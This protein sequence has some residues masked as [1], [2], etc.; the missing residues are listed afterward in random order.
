MENEKKSI[1]LIA[2]EEEENAAFDKYFELKL[3]KI[4][5]NDHGSL[6]VIISDI[7]NAKKLIELQ[8][9][10]HYKDRLLASISHDLR[11]PLNGVIGM[12]N[13]T[14]TQISD[15]RSKELLNI[16]LKSAHLLEFLIKDILDF[17]QFSYKKLRLNVDF[18]SLDELLKEVMSLMKF[19]AQNREI[20]LQCCN[21]IKK[22]LVG[23]SDPNRIKQILINLLGNAIKFT[24][25][26]FVK[27]S[28]D[29]A[30]EQDEIAINDEKN[31][32]LKFTVEDSGIGIK[33]EDQCH[34]FKL[35]GKLE[36]EDPE[37]NKNGIGL[38]LAI[39]NTLA[40]LL[41]EDERKNGIHLD[42]V[43]GKGSV[44]SFC[45]MIGLDNAV[46]KHCT[47]NALP[48]STNLNTVT[49][50][51]IGSPLV[52]KEEEETYILLVDDDALNL[53][54]LEKYLEKSRFSLLKARNGAEAV[55]IVEEKA[56]REMK[57]IALILM[58]CNMPVMN[59]FL[60]TENIGKCLEKAGVKNIPI[61]GVTANA[62][63]SETG[64]GVK[65]GMREILM[66]PVK[67]E[68]LLKVVKE[69]C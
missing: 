43:F 16:A 59:G 28:V 53:F 39:S 64:S 25:Q 20:Y 3:S 41:Y 44:F 32:L 12:I 6:L 26:G 61:V 62:V 24:K 17:S 50:S 46:Q 37:I 2:E 19:Q 11:T 65:A 10:D 66:K 48:T 13:T 21:H 7:T 38:G 47:Y 55:Q 58:D 4:Q 42:S 34:L 23:H 56:V 9:R 63:A 5:W 52:K 29:F 40:K 30:D 51:S 35:F 49:K 69:F 15:E 67:K 31:L 57:R 14:I 18:F 36:Q 8:N 54:V 33:R 45:V 60:A 1:F 22:N 68:E 27:L